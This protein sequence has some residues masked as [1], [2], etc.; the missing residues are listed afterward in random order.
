LACAAAYD[1]AFAVHRPMSHWGQE[2]AC[3]QRC[4]HGRRPWESRPNRCS[5]PNG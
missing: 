5:A 2:F 4:L 3:R 1:E